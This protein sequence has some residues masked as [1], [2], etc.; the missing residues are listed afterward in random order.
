MPGGGTPKDYRAALSGDIEARLAVRRGDLD[1]A[2]DETRPAFE[3]WQIH[4]SNVWHDHPELAMRFQLAEILR[5]EGAVEQAEWLFRSMVPPYGWLG[6]YTARSSYELALIEE[7]RGNREEAL[8]HYSRAARLWER[9]EPE[10][11]G[12]WLEAARDGLRR[13]RGELASR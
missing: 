13:L 12:R 8:R 11:V 9:G 5:T 10:V 6:F 2:L 3:N 7:E 4:S 1:T